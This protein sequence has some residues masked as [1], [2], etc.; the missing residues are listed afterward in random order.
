MPFRKP[1]TRLVAALL[2]A[3]LGLSACQKPLHKQHD[4]LLLFGTFVEVTILDTDEARAKAALAKVKDDLEYMHYVFHP[5]KAGPMGRTNQLLAAAGEFTANPSVIPALKKAKALERQSL[6]YFNPAIGRL[7]GLWGFHSEFA[8]EG[9]P[10][11]PKDIEKLVRQH[12]S[13]KSISIHGV[14]VKNTN[15]AVQLDFGGFAKGFALDQVMRHLK[16]M[17]IKN[18]IVNAGGDLNVLGRHDDRP[19][20]I[21]IRHPRQHDAVI[22][23]LDAQDGE[24]VYTS[25]DYERYYEYKGRRY[26]H[27]IDPRTGYPPQYTTSVTVIDHNGARADAAATA[28]FIAGPQHWQKVASAMGIKYVMLIDDKGVVH[29]TKPMRRRVKFEMPVKEIRIE[30]LK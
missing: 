24:A 20:H 6:G 12:P 25:G 8:P 2:L 27:L 11:D 5:W 21:G 22:A 1:D 3:C 18:A 4:T 15:A 30:P 13:M 28:L 23:S 14:R 17:G 16:Q 10:P 26:H 7:I 29:I 9:P 19:W